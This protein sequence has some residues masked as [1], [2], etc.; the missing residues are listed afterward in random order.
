MA[1]DECAF[2]VDD[3][4]VSLG[5]K[6]GV[7]VHTQPDPGV[8]LGAGGEGEAGGSAEFAAQP[9]Q[10][11]LGAGAGGYPGLGGE[12]EGFLVALGEF[13]GAGDQSDRHGQLLLSGPDQYPTWCHVWGAVH[14]PGPGLERSRQARLVFDLI[15]E[16]HEMCTL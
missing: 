1:D 10:G 16:M 13:L 5:S 2:A 14:S 7:G 15:G 8:G 3:Q 12:C 4:S 11:V 6:A 9:G